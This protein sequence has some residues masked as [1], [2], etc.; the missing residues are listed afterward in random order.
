MELIESEV[1]APAGAIVSPVVASRSVV[2]RTA[3]WAPAVDTEPR[4]TVLVC[5]GRSEFIEKY[6]EVVADLRRRGFAV[7]VFDWRGQGMSDRQLRDHRKGHIWTFREFEDDL[8]AVRRQ[9]LE[10]FCPRPWFA[11]GHSMG[12]PVVLSFASRHPDVFRRIVLSAPMIDIAG[13]PMPNMARVLARCACGLGIGRHVVPL[14]RNRSLFFSTFDGNVLTSDKTRFARTASLLE[15]EPRLSIGPPTY[16]WINAA[17]DCIASLDH[18]QFGRDFMTPTLIVLPSADVVI[19]RKAVERLAR[20]LRTG[21]L[22][23]VQ[24][25]RHEVLM[26]RDDLRQQFWSAFDAFVPGSVETGGDEI[27]TELEGELGVAAL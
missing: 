4:G 27:F 11:L 1:K 18:E 2:L 5:T 22:V 16:G 19:D 21:T 23:N 15:V 12:G 9:V 17:F 25:A 3:R 6:Y 26:E 24:G 7:L 8:D 20:R 14:G 10:P 13:L